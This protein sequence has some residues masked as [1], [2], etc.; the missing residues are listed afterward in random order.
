MGTGTLTIDLNAIADNWHALDA[1]SAPR[2]ATAAVVKADGYG[3]S[4]RHVARKLASAGVRQFFVAVAEEGAA[5]RRAVGPEPAIN[6]FSGHMTG[7]ASLLSHDNL[8]PMLNSMEQYTRHLQQLPGHPFGVQLDTGMNRLGMEPGEWALAAGS[9]LEKEPVLM[10]SHLACADDPNDPMNE[11]QLMMFRK[12]TDGTGVPR[13]LAATG[14]ILL[15]SHYHFD[16]T[17]PGIGIYG[18]AP[19]AAAKT[20]IRLSLPVIQRRMLTP[21]ESVGYGATW[22]ARNRARIATVSAGYADGL[23]RRLG[24]QAM[25]YSGSTPCRLAGRI[26][27]DLLTVDVSHLDEAP[28]QLDLFCDAQNI[29]TLAEA[30]GTINY[31]I[32]TQLGGRYGRTYIGEAR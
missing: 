1:M 6:V 13:S 30:A 31:E 2:V 3:L 9:V 20:V 4:A 32:L 11:R 28:E 22:T 15:G 23:I 8:T 5:V 10:M 29:E 18:G 27:M 25:L 7:D 26:S 16:L 24:D 21:G 17:R 19:F 14:G 12:L